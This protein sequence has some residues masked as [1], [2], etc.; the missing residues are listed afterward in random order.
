MARLWPHHG[1]RSRPGQ[2][3]EGSKNRGPQSQLTFKNSSLRLIGVR[4]SA[5][6]TC[7]G[8]WCKTLQGEE[9]ADRHSAA[10]G[11]DP[12]R[13]PSCLKRRR[14]QMRLDR[15]YEASAGPSPEGALRWR[16]PVG[17]SIEGPPHPLGSGAAAPLCVPIASSRSQQLLD[18]LSSNRKTTITILPSTS[19]L[20]SHRSLP[21][22]RQSP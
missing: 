11:P 8:E 2:R 15:Q 21:S 10:S 5:A 6:R 16:L 3:G 4:K 17:Q 14:C 1:G 13:P 22:Q 20:P 9:D 18:A 7:V 19:E 12:R